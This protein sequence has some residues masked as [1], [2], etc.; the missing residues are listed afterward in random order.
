LPRSAADASVAHDPREPIEDRYKSYADYRAQFQKALDEL[1]RER[2][3]LAE[4]SA[5]LISRSREEWEWITQQVQ[6]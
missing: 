1:V 6:K 5:Q 3:I 4:D 2:Y